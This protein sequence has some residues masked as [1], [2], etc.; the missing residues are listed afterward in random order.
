M[1]NARQA[2]RAA[3]RAGAV[4]YA[5]AELEE[6]RRLLTEAKANLNRGDYRAA[7]DGAEQSREKAVAARRLAETATAAAPKPQP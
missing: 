7:R 4:T 1:S 6:A 3:E 2:V 5:P